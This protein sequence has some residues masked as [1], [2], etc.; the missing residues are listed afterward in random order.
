MGRSTD[1][2]NPEPFE[3]IGTKDL[4]ESFKDGQRVRGSFSINGVEMH[5]F[6]AASPVR[7]FRPSTPNRTSTTSP[8]RSMTA[9]TSFWSTVPAPSR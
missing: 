4:R 8:Q 1:T 6:D 2:R 9:A 7:W 3:L 5:Q